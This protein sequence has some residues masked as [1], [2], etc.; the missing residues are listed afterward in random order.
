VTAI[1]GGADEEVAVGNERSTTV[2]DGVCVG[3]GIC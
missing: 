2:G 3:A 1:V